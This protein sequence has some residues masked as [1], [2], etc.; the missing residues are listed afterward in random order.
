[1]GEPVETLETCSAPACAPSASASIRPPPTSA[2]AT[3]TRAAS[4]SSSANGC[5]GLGYWGV[6]RRDDDLAFE[7]GI[8]FTDIVKRPTENAAELRAEEFQ[9]GRERLWTKVEEA[10][11]RLVIFTFKKTA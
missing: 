2:Q 7:S 8:G 9:H 4:A 10:Q 1:M 11:P 3:T 5:A 6:P